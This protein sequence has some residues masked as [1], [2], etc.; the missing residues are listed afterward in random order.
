MEAEHFLGGS[1]LFRRLKNGP[2]GELVER[3][4]GR[5]V[6]ERLAHKGTRQCLMWLAASWTGSQSVAASSPTSMSTWSSGT[7][8]TELADSPFRPV[9]AQR[10]GDGCRYCATRVRLRQRRRRG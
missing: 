5:L 10:S 3:Y 7:F 8:G 9:T 1:R 4:A 2:H 6:E